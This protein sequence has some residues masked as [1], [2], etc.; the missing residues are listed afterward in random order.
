MPH[1]IPPALDLFKLTRVSSYTF[2]VCVYLKEFMQCD[3]AIA[4]IHFKNLNNILSIVSL[5]LTL[6]ICYKC[7]DVQK[8][9][10]R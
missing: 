6:K 3:R 1:N 9:V 5:S 10:N 4:S 7:V 2:V 8:C